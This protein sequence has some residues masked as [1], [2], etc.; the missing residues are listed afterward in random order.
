MV[1]FVFCF[2]VSLKEELAIFL[3]S[4]I[5]KVIFSCVVRHVR[6]KPE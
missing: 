5:F 6:Y 1:L 4:A 2:I 3:K